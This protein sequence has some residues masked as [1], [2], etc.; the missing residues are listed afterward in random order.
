MKTNKHLCRLPFWAVLAL[1]VAPAQAAGD[2]QAER[3]RWALHARGGEQ[4]LSE[5]VAALQT[6]YGSSGDVRVRADLT[7]LLLR[8]GRSADALALCSG[9]LP[10]DYRPDEL[11]NLAKAARD[12]KQF[13][14][15]LALY[16]TLQQKAP[17]QKI[18]WLGGA[19][20]AVDAREYAAAKTHIAAYRQRFGEDA[21]LRAAEDYLQNQSQSLA[22]RIGVLQQR[23]EA[24]PGDRDTVLQL[25][26][27]AAGLQVYPVQ[28][29]LMAEYPQYFT[30]QDRRWLT[31]AEAV[32][33][34]RAAREAD[35]RSEALQAFRRLGEVA[36]QS[37]PGSDLY[38]RAMRDRIT[39]G[40]LSGNHKQAVRDYETLAQY[41][42]QPDY[43]Q[44][45]YAQALSATGSP[46]KA[47]RIY[48]ALVKK[49]E[50]AGEAVDAELIE[51]MVQ[52]DADLGHYS[53]AQYHLN[54]LSPNKMKPDFTHT[55]EVRNPFFDRQYF[56]QAR[57][58]AWNGNMK[59]AIGLMD[60]WLADHPADPW[61]MI[62]RGEL[63]QWNG[64]ND[65]ADKWFAEAMAWLPPESQAW[66]RTN[67]GA[68]LMDN[69]NWAGIKAM[70]AGIDR[71]NPDYAG[72]WQRYDD[73]RAAQLSV[74]GGIFKATS[75]RDSGNEWS[76]SA[77]LYSLRSQGGH[78]AY[79]TQQN[80]F[81]PN[82]GEELRHGRVGVGGELSF[83][84]FNINLEAGQGTHL[85]DKAYFN[86]GLDY[87]LNQHWS[88][89][90][91]AAVNS[92]NT[93]AKALSQ[94]VYANEYSLSAN[95]T[96]S[97][98][99]RAGFGA[100]VMDFD[101][102]NLR[103]GAYAWL[104]QTLWQRNRWKLGGSLWADYSRND[105]VPSAYYYNPKNSK[106]ASGDLNLSYAL[107]LDHNI[108]LTQNLGAGMGR[109]WQ[110][111]QDA[112]NTWVVKYGHDWSLGKRVELSYEAGRKKAIYD[113]DAEYQNFGNVGL[114]VR[115]Q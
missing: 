105:D 76:Q 65:E 17:Q 63:A 58:E 66:V 87:R 74:S 68:I 103:R 67:R 25:Y 62:L 5:S 24:Q 114:N 95:Y 22:E 9:C 49:H 56:W 94:D 84:P 35:S 111:G 14:R 69:G 92:A 54:T 29:K 23:L 97:A 1:S 28:E 46:N 30:P 36:A 102:G 79:I 73:A 77:T 104:S 88:F 83:Y 13:E 101:D 82:H 113:G 20:A 18:G 15:A 99:T 98:A 45:A 7:A 6:L 93:P 43:V 78:R 31:H 112:E 59:G 19:L 2:V 39:A 100:S 110:A 57:L 85:N 64:R 16:Q 8:Q 50:Q 109:Y 3:E 80:G 12:N 48:H 106:S 4:Q 96:H 51:K 90:A 26:R 108:R 71:N 55:S 34:L 52:N 40:A 33:Q 44:D 60:N 42:E 81:V 11:E 70:A 115:F 38:L 32:S 72:F 47:G 91:R 86:A 41:G 107:P 27:A 75:P 37:E 10:G 61:A 53:R 21:D 89:N